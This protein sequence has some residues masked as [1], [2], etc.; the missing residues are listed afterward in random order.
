MVIKMTHRMMLYY[1]LGH[2]IKY[3]YDT[4]Y[5]TKN[6]HQVLKHALNMHLMST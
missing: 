4:L 3:Q 5:M 2:R 1:A 6:K